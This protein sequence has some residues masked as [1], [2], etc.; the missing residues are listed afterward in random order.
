MEKLRIYL[1]TNMIHSWFRKY[2][3]AKKKNIEF[4]EPEILKF[5]F[6]LKNEYIVS[7]IVK[8]EIFRFLAAEYDA[9]ENE[10]GETWEK[11]VRTY[12]IVYV[13]V[14]EINFE[15]LIRICLIVKTKKKTLIN[16][17]HM[18]VAKQGNVLFLTGEE[19]LIEKYKQYYHK[20]LSYEELREMFS[21]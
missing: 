13:I 19:R 7:N 1:D 21:V 9:N 4:L 10:C 20:T 6:G 8:T 18:Q 17:M 5:I 3:D 11:F 2:M 15:E 12:N 14:K 16:L